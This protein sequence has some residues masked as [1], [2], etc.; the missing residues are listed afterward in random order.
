MYNDYAELRDA[1]GMK[2]MDVSRAL[3]LHPSVISDWRRG[4]STPK[5]DKLVLIANYFDVS[6]DFLMTGKQS[7][8]YYLN[9]E[10]AKIAQEIF[11]NRELRILF[12]VSRNATPEQLKLL[13]DLAKSW[14]K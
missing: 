13:Q 10:T 3:G 11:D 7:D 5:Y 2:D 6:V 12:D 8:N 14:V 9:P 1:R 4:K